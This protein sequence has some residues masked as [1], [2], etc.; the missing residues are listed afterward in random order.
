MALSVLFLGKSSSPLVLLS[1][2]IIFIGFMVGTALDA[3]TYDSLGFV[4]GVFSAGTTAAH[5][6]VIKK[7]LNVIGD[8]TMDL[9]YYNNLLSAIVLLPY[10]LFSGELGLAAKMLSAEEGNGS[11]N[12]DPLSVFLLGSFLTVTSLSHAIAIL[13][14]HTHY[15]DL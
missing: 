13:A 9:V 15:I 7:T 2:A 14:S 8:N 12:L 10:I 11:S 3:L 6:I 5:A 1:C 4:F